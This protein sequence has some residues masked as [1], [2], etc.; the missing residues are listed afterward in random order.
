VAND[1]FTGFGYMTAMIE[2]K[3]EQLDSIKGIVTEIAAGLATGPISDDE[4]A[5]ARQP[6]LT[7]LEQMRRDNRY[8]SQNVLRNSHEH[9][10]RLK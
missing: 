7:Q 4:F 6:L 9:P 1:T 5:R 3:P 2:V 10:E 8:W